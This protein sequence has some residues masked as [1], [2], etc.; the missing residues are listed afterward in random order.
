ML[1]LLQ[2]CVDGVAIGALF[3]LASVGFALIYSTTRTFHFAHGGTMILAAYAYYESVSAWRWPIVAALGFS[4]AVAIVF[5]VGVDHFVYQ[6]MRRT[7]ASFLTLF[8]A[9]FGLLIVATN[10]VVLAFGS[11]FYSV[12]SNLGR[13]F[14]VGPILV[15]RADVYAVIV[16]AALIALLQWFMRR[17]RTGVVLRAM[18]DDRELVDVF[19]FDSRRYSVVAFL[20]GSALIVPVAV[21]TCYT[22]GL[23]PGVGAVITLVSIAAAIVG[24]I[25]S[26]WGAALGGLLLGIAE[27][28]GV[29]QFSSSWKPAIAF[30]VLL[31]FLMFRPGGI[32]QLRSRQT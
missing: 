30:G 18:M 14:L 5:G 4:V 10:V 28:A 8:A 9:S 19:G 31:A 3:A 22:S 24:G 1:T 15:S 21:L 16:A 25:R 26:L 13:G 6:P 27:N 12:S 32:V 17:T 7:K 20:V 23:Q 29:W 2:L 11:G